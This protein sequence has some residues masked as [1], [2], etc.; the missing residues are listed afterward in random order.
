MR[1][2]TDESGRK[3][4]PSPDIIHPI[5]L[6]LKHPTTQQTTSEVVLQTIMIKVEGIMNSKL[7][8]YLSSNTADPD[9]ITPNLLTM[10]RRDASLPQAMRKLAE[11]SL[12]SQTRKIVLIFGPQ[13]PWAPWA[14]GCVTTGRDGCVRSVDFQVGSRSFIRPVSRLMAL[15]ELVE[16]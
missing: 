14:T 6:D 8:G 9:P 1:C 10:G 12:E 2:G 15:P 5:I 7:L 4:T 11:G 16:E 3:T 13:L